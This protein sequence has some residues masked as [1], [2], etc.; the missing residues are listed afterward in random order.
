MVR[1]MMWT[2]PSVWRIAL[3]GQPGKPRHAD[4]G[5]TNPFQ[6]MNFVF[7]FLT[8]DFSLITPTVCFFAFALERASAMQANS[9]VVRSMGDK[10]SS[11]VV[12][13]P[14]GLSLYADTPEEE[15]TLEDVEVYSFSRLKGEFL[16]II[17]ARVFGVFSYVSHTPTLPC[18]YSSS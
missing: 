13:S 3:A 10:S 5:V 16:F 11:A 2:L 8:R 12:R 17:F 6:F 9:R 15:I 7:M 14:C 4:G 18:P 1:P